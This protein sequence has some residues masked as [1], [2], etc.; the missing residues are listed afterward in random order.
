MSDLP[1]RKL[2]KT[3]HDVSV[4]GWGGAP[5][6]FLRADQEKTAQTLNTLLDAGVNLIDQAT[7]YR[8]GHEFMGEHF[9][10]RRDDFVL[11]SKVGAMSGGKH[12]WTEAGIK[13]HVDD[14]LV[15]MKTDRIDVMLLHS[16]PMDVLEAD[17]ALGAL[18]ECRE[19][20]KI[21]HCGYSGD[22]DEAAFACRLPD[23]AVLETSVSLVYQANLDAGIEKATQ[24]DVGVI[25]KR[26]IANAAWKDLADQQGIY[27]QYAKDYTER[28]AKMDVK[29][30]DF[31]CDDWPELAFRFTLAQ[32]ITTAIIGTTNAEHA[33]ANVAAVKKGPLPVDAVAQIKQAYETARGDADWPGL[34]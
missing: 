32:P 6:S 1:R 18:V 13:Q 33:E 4:L 8:G 26:P 25:A 7:M 17:E 2:G 9:A 15:A 31:G 11:V 14:A 34:T 28:L 5:A 12:D 27:K 22:N 21:V 19:A 29:P 30:G 24:H 3:G 20:G 23:V 10:D 16:C